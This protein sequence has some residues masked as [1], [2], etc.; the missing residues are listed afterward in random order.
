MLLAACSM[1]L[2][3]RMRV[4]SRCISKVAALTGLNFDVYQSS[5][6]QHLL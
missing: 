5:D 2:S 3:L 1:L 6:R 4:A